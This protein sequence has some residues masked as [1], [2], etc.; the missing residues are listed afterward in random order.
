MV[1]L[2]KNAC[3]GDVVRPIEA[4]LKAWIRDNHSLFRSVALIS[5]QVFDFFDDFLFK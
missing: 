4:F 3:F 2:N 1:T 5:L